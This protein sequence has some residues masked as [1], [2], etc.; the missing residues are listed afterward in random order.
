MAEEERG[1]RQVLSESH[2][3]ARRRG[4]QQVWI[5]G[6]VEAT[7]EVSG[8]GRDCCAHA[9]QRL[10]DQGAQWIVSAGFA[11]A[12]DGDLSLGDIVVADRVL[13]SES[14]PIK[15]DEALTEAVPPSGTLGYAVH[16][17]DLI[18]SDAVVCRS[19]DKH[20]INT[21]TGAAALDMESYAA[22]QVCRRRDVPF[23]A[24]RSISDTSDQ[25]IPDEI[26]ELASMESLF[27]RAG[28]ILSRPLIWRDL[29]TLRSQAQA[30]ATNLGDVL[31]IMLLR[32]I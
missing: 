12:L 11:A 15:C 25:D 14:Q 29:L 20:R 4:S 2:L 22:A 17:C 32:L 8:T 9:T 5:V 3:S 16:R 31:G 26:P 1:F 24:I 6:D 28:F 21:Y 18:T 10:I 30:A 23:S 7:V 19:S 27:S 13:L